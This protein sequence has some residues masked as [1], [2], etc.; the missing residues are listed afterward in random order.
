MKQQP[1][2]RGVLAF[3][4]AEETS[5]NAFLFVSAASPHQGRLREY[6][7]SL[8]RKRCTRPSW[9]VLELDSEGPVARAALWALPDEEVPTDMVLIDLD[10]GE[11]DLAA[12]DS[13]RSRNSP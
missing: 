2:K 10:W 12:D 4:T 6:A 11:E 8:I 3:V 1:S 5:M 13:E 9:C 7:Y